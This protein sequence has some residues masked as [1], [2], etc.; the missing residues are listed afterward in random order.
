MPDASGMTVRLA[1]WQKEDLAWGTRL[2]TWQKKRHLLLPKPPDSVIPAKAGN[3][4]CRM[5]SYR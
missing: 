1:W 4:L 3:Q 5:V 2:I